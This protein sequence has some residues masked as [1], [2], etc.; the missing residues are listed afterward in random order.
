MQKDRVILPQP[1]SRR[2]GFFQLSIF[3]VF[4]LLLMENKISENSRPWKNSMMNRSV[5]VLC[6][7]G[8]ALPGPKH[9]I[10]LQGPSS[11]CGLGIQCWFG[12]LPPFLFR[13]T[14][15]YLK[16]YGTRLK[17]RRQQRK[18][19]EKGKVEVVEPGSKPTGQGPG[20]TRRNEQN[21]TLCNGW[22]TGCGAHIKLREGNL[23]RALPKGFC[24]WWH[25]RFIH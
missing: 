18:R 21:W 15:Q 16:H 25:I 13:P 17:R 7:P 6:Y 19:R 5:S 23:G 3:V 11:L 10:T 24:D 20:R 9:N 2:V 1:W 22:L 4:W 12:R 8:L 14:F